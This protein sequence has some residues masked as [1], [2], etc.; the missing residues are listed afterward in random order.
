M[1]LKHNEKHNKNHIYNFNIFKEMLYPKQV[2]NKKIILISDYKTIEKINEYYIN[3]VGLLCI[4]ILLN[5]WN[6]IT[7]KR[8][9]SFFAKRI[10]IE[11]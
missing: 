11:V 4:D 10:V 2:P 9:I 1:A 3:Y 6:D 7:I 5:M 8:N